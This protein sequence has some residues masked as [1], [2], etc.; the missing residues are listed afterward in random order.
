MSIPTAIGLMFCFAVVGAFLDRK[1]NKGN[2]SSSDFDD[3]II[4]F[5]GDDS[6][7]SDSDSS[8]D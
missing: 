5:S 2:T 7:S 1:K 3:D 4:D 6:G 8:D